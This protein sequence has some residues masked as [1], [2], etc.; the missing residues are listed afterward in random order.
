M[1]IEIACHIVDDYDYCRRCGLKLT[2]PLLAEQCT[3][4]DDILQLVNR[5]IASIVAT[6]S[7]ERDVQWSLRS[8]T[9]QA[10][11]RTPK[12]DP[13]AARCDD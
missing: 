13:D 3:P 10:M 5:R 7:I 6:N 9:D 8:L 12:C 1:T 4:P 2:V 11:R